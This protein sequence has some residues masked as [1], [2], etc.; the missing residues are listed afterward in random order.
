MP[1]KTPFVTTMDYPD[2]IEYARLMWTSRAVV[3]PMKRNLIRAVGQQTYLNAMLLEKPTIVTDALGVRDHV[4][5][6]ETAIVVDGSPQS[7]VDSIRKVL[8]P[9]NKTAIDKMCNFARKTVLEQ[10][11]FQD[12]AT[13]LLA[14]L[15]GAVQEWS[16]S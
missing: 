5:D 13:R 8:D 9:A 10:Y 6:G 11:N 16:R 15:D 2:H 4:R 1:E 12:H 3:V 14:V 7:Y